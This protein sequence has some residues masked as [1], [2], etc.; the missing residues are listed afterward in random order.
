MRDEKEVEDQERTRLIQTGVSR[1]LEVLTSDE[2]EIVERIH[3]MGQSYREM[4][5]KSGRAMHRL[6]ALHRRAIKRLRKELRPLVKELYGIDSPLPKCVICRS[7]MRRE[8]DRIIEQHDERRSWRV[9]IQRIRD[10]CG[11]RIR[12]PQ[13]L[14]GH[15]KY[16]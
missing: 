7:P 8:I 13:T 10:E 6:E 4:S 5:E 12:T 1:A 15:R 9:V 3:F 2:R 11:V 16:H 14:I